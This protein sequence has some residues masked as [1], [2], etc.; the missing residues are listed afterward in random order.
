MKIHA[1][2]GPFAGDKDAAAHIR[3]TYILPTV[4]K[5]QSAV[6]DF[7]DV[8][9]A[10]QS[11]IHALVASVVRQDPDA[12]D[13]IEFKNCNQQIQDI[14]QIVVEYSQSEFG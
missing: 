9:L 14:I 10:T 13:V 5:S 3:E 12:L 2:T 1:S 4:E 11:F 7:V 8:E 6:L